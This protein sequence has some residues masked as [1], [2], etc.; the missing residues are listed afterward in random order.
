MTRILTALAAI[1]L[2]AIPPFPTPTSVFVSQSH[3]TPTITYGDEVKNG[4]YVATFRDPTNKWRCIV[5][6]T[7][8]VGMGH[9]TAFTLVCSEPQI[10]PGE[11]KK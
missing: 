5:T 2:Q 9:I 7:N 6:S 8:I 11:E 4:E 10:V 1:L 3:S